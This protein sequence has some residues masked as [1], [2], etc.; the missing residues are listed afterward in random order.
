MNRKK[1]R[2][3]HNPDATPTATSSAEPQHITEQVNPTML[4]AST[5]TQ[6]DYYWG[7]V[8]SGSEEDYYWRRLSD[9][10][11]QKD[12]LPSTYLEMH[13]LVYEAWNA[14]PLATTI[15]EITT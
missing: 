8:A 10:W 6:E 14:N 12:L 5:P 1:R 7:R 9:H 4:S 3:L 2:S 11:W 13:N 15:I